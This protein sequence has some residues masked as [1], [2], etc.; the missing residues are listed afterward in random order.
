MQPYNQTKTTQPDINRYQEQNDTPCIP[1]KTEKPQKLSRDA[2]S[3]YRSQRDL[4]NN[5]IDARSIQQ[6]ALC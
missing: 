2:D 5:R 4:Y 3:I 1:H 6:F